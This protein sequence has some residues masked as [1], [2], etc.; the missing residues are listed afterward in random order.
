LI[1]AFVLDFLLPDILADDAFLS[2][3]CGDIIDIIA[4]NPIDQ[5]FVELPSSQPYSQG[6]NSM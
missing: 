6:E 1:E 4:N 3:Y 5:K 2:P